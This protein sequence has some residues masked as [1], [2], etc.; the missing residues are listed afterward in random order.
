VTI[1]GTDFTGFAIGRVSVSRGRRTVYETPNAGYCSVELRDVGGMPD[2]TVGSQVRVSVEDSAGSAVPVFAGV[3]SDWDSATLAT[4]GEPVVVYRV[5]AVGPLARL[6]RRQVLAGGRPSEDDGER[7]LAA[8]GGLSPSWE[9]LGFGVTWDDFE[10]SWAEAGG[11]DPALVDPGV[12]VLAALGSADAGYNALQVA[13]DAGF[14][15]QGVLYETAAGGIGYADADRRFA[16]E[17]AGFLQVPSG[18]L[19][20]EG[21]RVSQRLADITNRVTVE[22]DGG[23]VQSDDPFSISTFGLF[24]S[25]IRTILVDVGNAQA[26]ADDFVARHAVPQDVVE[27]LPVNLLSVGT[28]LRDA[29]LA[30]EVNDAVEVT[31]IPARLGFTD[32]KGFVEGVRVDV[33]SFRADL[34]L[35]VSDRSL[36]VGSLRW[37]QVGGTVTW[38]SVGTAVTWADTRVVFYA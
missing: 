4:G 25:D 22:Y 26:R 28:A 7:V 31:D 13:Q 18:L 8:L 12:Y 15:G 19:S 27:E 33:D 17:Q 32:F 6:N 20:V 24:E 37:G 5:Q 35:T 16:N 1:G 29:L 30:V 14:S 36:S 21:L 38:D 23:A 9:E 34:I 10:G 11:F 3:L 2:L